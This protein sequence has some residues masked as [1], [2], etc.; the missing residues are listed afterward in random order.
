M[1]FMHNK[2]CNKQDG[3]FSSSR[4]YLHKGQDHEMSFKRHINHLIS[5]A[6]VC[7]MATFS[8]SIIFCNVNNNFKG[9]HKLQGYF[10]SI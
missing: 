8:F 4:S 10:K 7:F 1:T 6:H 9:F 2:L 3:F 5:S